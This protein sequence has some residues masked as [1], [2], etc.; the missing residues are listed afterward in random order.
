MPFLPC[1]ALSLRRNALTDPAK[2]FTDCYVNKLFYRGT[3]RRIADI[4]AAQHLI[5]P[6][7]RQ[8][9]VALNPALRKT[10]QNLS[11]SVNVKTTLRLQLISCRQFGKSE[12]LERSHIC[13]Q[14]SSKPKIYG[15]YYW[16][17]DDLPAATMEIKNTVA[18]VTAIIVYWT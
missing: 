12:V 9:S 14:L 15:Y 3:A 1:R 2:P 6:S 4:F 16:R 8:C 13:V 17:F 18:A 10:L 5:T 11:P 7:V